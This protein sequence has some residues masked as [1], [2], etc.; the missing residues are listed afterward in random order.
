MDDFSEEGEILK[1]ASDCLLRLRNALWKAEDLTEEVIEILRGHESEISEL[2]EINI[3]ADR[4]QLEDYGIFRVPNVINVINHN[5]YQIISQF[6]GVLDDFDH[7]YRASLP[8]KRVVELSCDL[9]K[10]HMKKGMPM[11]TK[12]C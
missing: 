4:L 8:F 2:E 10:L 12:R 7:K 9:R 5:S 3:E 1:K 6:P 11:R